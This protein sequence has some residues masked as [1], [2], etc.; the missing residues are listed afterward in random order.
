MD[1]AGRAFPRRRPLRRRVP[2]TEP[3]DPDAAR[4]AGPAPP[5]RRCALAGSR[6]P[7]AS[8]RPAE[9]RRH[10]AGGTFSP[11]A[12]RV[13]LSASQCPSVSLIGLLAQRLSFLLPR[14]LPYWGHLANPT[15]VLDTI[16]VS[17]WCS[18]NAEKAGSAVAREWQLTWVPTCL[19]TQASATEPLLPGQPPGVSCAHTQQ[20]PATGN[21][22]GSGA[23]GT[24]S[25]ED[26]NPSSSSVSEKVLDLADTHLLAFL[27]KS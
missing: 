22:A 19:V 26:S 3:P 9:E 23:Q 25:T 20:P 8:Q 14:A 1:V 15:A 13:S 6:P 5:R 2:L 17:S 24:D 7:A 27:K 10:G 21:Q 16:P 18:E 11:P 4:A 12:A